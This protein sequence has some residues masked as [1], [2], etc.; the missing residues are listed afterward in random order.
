MVLSMTAMP[1]AYEGRLSFGDDVTREAVPEAMAAALAAARGAPYGLS[2]ETPTGDDV[3]R[4]VVFRFDDDGVRYEGDL[5]ATRPWREA[6]LSPVEA[7]AALARVGR[8]LAGLHARGLAHGDLREEMLR[9]DDAGAVT[10][11]FPAHAV[12][13]GA[14]LRARLHP[15]GAHAA[16]VAFAAPESVA[17][18][19]ATP[20][21]DVYSLAALAYATLTGRAPL[22]QVSARG[23]APLA[24]LVTWVRAAL[25]QSPTARPTMDALAAALARGAAQTVEGALGDV[26]DAAPPPATEPAPE[27]SPVLLTVLIAGGFC[28]FVGAVL[29]VV[30]VGDAVGAA[31]RVA[32]L[33]GLAALSWGV[34]LVARRYRVE[35]GVT[36]ARGLA[37]LFATVAVAYT[38]S[39]L[40]ELGRL[41]LL[42]GLSLSAVAGGFVVERR[43]AP[44]GGAVLLALGSQLLWIVGAQALTMRGEGEDPGALAA[45]AACVSLVTF[46]LA[47]QRR[48]GHLGVLAALDVAAFVSFFGAWIHRGTVMGPPTYALGV[49]ALYALLAGVATWRGATSTAAPMALGAAGAAV[50]SAIAGLWVVSQHWE[51]HG[52]LGAAWPFAV[53][54]AA[55]P[56]LRAPPPLKGAAAFVAGGVVVVAPTVEALLRRELAF[57]VFAAVAGAVVLAVASWWPALRGRDDARAEAFLGGVIGVT[58][59]PGLRLLRAIIATPGGWMRPGEGALWAIVACGAAGLL[60]LSYAVTRRVGRTQHRM[61]EAGALVPLY[62]LLT[63]QVL[64]AQREVA[65]AALALGSSSAL[66]ALGVATRRAAVMVT[67]AA[68]L[69]VHLWAQYFIRLEDVLPLSVRLVGFG[70][71][72]LVGGVLY[73]QQVRHRLSA[74]KD[75]D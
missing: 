57:T 7:L 32:T 26:F 60:A 67:S 19:T 36:V 50:V 59:A 16:A 31:G 43:G 64:A 41:A 20:A 13:P 1:G 2:I 54:L 8:C 69:I 10:L 18:A 35:P 22:G 3:A 66:L 29:L 73:E 49:A 15:G 39:L 11:L 27:I 44:L 17:G 65:P 75:W 37:G 52:L 23:P 38:F 12:A 68:A 28:A 14:V 46:A 33:V 56:L 47:A 62:V 58:A 21:A 30:A 72:L 34:S 25:D 55:A 4:V 6:T 61:L 48:S 63:A 51:T 53:A 24:E 9:V 42:A 70:V 45:L 71:G 40:D 5:S 74:L